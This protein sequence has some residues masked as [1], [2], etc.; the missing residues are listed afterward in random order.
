ML[1]IVLNVMM[2]QAIEFLHDL[3][4][5]Q[6]IALI[7]ATLSGD[8]KAVISTSS[9]NHNTPQKQSYQQQ[10]QHNTPHQYDPAN[11]S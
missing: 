1:L 4:K 11:P 8:I 9:G 3:N 5:G 7:D 6:S 10:S 2:Q